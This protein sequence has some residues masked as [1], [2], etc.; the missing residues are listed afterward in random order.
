MDFNNI[1]SEIYNEIKAIPSK[2][3]VAQY[4]PELA[5][6][7]P[8]KF[9]VSLV[10]LDGEKFHFGNAQEK[11]SIQSIA[12]VLSLTMAYEIQGEKLW[13]RVGVE[14]SGT[15]FNSLVQLEYEKGIPR[16]PFINAGALVIA[17]ILVS[18]LKN[19]KKEFLDFVNQLCHTKVAYSPQVAASE[20][21]CAYVNTALINLMKSFGNIKNDINEVMDFY[22][23]LCSI[24]M[25]CEELS[26]TFLFLA[27]DGVC[28]LSQKVIV[29]Q[30]KSKRINSIMQLCGFYDEAGEFSFKVGLPGKSGVG[31]GIVVVRPHEFSMAVW[32]PRLNAKGN[33]FLGTKF[34]ELFTTKIDYS[35][36]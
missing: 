8:E 5:L 35:I 22:F 14:P 3:S 9:G 31:G 15:A 17:D 12:K 13:E 16:N 28:A 10:N 26:Q 20:K 18:E 2:G 30:S 29:D 21:S 4:I 27:N 25:T 33:S 6:V 32:S 36:F 1:F 34:L 24:E 7:D 11:F 19:P 23:H